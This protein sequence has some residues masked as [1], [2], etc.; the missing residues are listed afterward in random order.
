ML[1]LQ[2]IL[3]PLLLAKQPSELVLE[4]GT[5]NPFAPPF[6]FM[7]QAFLPLLKR[8]GFRVEAT[9]ERAGFYPNGGGR[10]RVLIQTSEK[11]G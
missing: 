1:L 3:P 9:L 10:C 2:T 8:L 4:G 11:P 5:H 7:A 6:P